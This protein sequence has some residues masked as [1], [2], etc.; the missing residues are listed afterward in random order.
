MNI[1]LPQPTAYHRYLWSKCEG[2]PVALANELVSNVVNDQNPQAFDLLE[3]TGD[4]EYTAETFVK[5][6]KLLT[7]IIGEHSPNYFIPKS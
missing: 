1:E 7:E 6:A 2:H 4:I 3:L 5:A